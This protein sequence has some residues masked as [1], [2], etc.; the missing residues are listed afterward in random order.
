M[1]VTVRCMAT[2]TLYLADEQLAYVERHRG[3][4]S[5]SAWIAQAVTER[6]GHAAGERTPAPVV[7]RS[8]GPA[9]DSEPSREAGPWTGELGG[10]ALPAGTLRPRVHRHSPTC[11]CAV[12]KPV[13]S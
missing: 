10:E 13:K 9:V 12:C 1:S 6:K 5:R 8:P 3:P 7:E 11:S 4:I 2:F